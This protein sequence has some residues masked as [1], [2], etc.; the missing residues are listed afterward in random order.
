MAAI[1]P[2]SIAPGNPVSSA[3]GRTGIETTLGA[4]D[5]FTYAPGDI[6]HLRNPTGGSITVNL[7]GDAAV[8]WPVPL[9]EPLGVS[10]G[11]DVVVPAGAER[12]V[13]LDSVA[14]YLQ[15]TVVNV[16]G[17]TGLVAMLLRS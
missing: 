14:G 12:A 3:A 4:A 15:G 17:G 2:T 13:P 11:L 10:A 5:T 8:T 16:T 9:S 6:L 1:S 7:K